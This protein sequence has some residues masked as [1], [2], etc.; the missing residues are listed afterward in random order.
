MANYR[1]AV[2]GCGRIGSTIDDEQ[3][4]RPLFRY[5]S[6]RRGTCEVGLRAHEQHE[7]AASDDDL[8]G[9]GMIYYENGIRGFLNT[10]G[11]LNIDFVGSDRW[12]SA[13][14][15]HADFE[16]WSRLPTT[17]EPVRR[18]FPNPKRPRSS[19]QA[20]IEGLVGT[21]TSAQNR[22]V[23]ANMDARPLRSLSA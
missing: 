23:P 10:G 12:I 20:S 8:R 17:R 11:W 13:R 3:V 7:E 18:Q 14:N 19:Q 21:L 1:G 4:G 2:I 15:E 22:C 16:M 5:P 6:V 9:T